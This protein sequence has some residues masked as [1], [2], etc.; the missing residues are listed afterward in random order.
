VCSGARRIRSLLAATESSWYVDSELADYVIPYRFRQ[1]L[2][3]SR[4]LSGVAAA[5]QLI[6]ALDLAAVP[7]SRMT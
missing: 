3:V 2:S 5:D 1:R 6:A 7:S 4:C